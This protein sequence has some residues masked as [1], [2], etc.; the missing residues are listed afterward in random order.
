MTQW[1]CAWLSQSAGCR[2]PEGVADPS[3][4]GVA[5]ALQ[6]EVGPLLHKYKV[7]VAF[8]GHN[9]AYQVML[10]CPLSNPQLAAPLGHSSLCLSPAKRSTHTDDEFGALRCVMGCTSRSLATGLGRDG[11]RMTG[12]TAVVRIQLRGLDVRCAQ[13]RRAASGVR[14]PSRARAC[15][16]RHGRRRLHREQIR[17]AVHGGEKPYLS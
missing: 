13:R 5:D 9:H 2:C 14:R 11:P 7:D 15:G 12:L 17:R 6:R 16:S 8:W 4:S 3:D 1:S 10:T